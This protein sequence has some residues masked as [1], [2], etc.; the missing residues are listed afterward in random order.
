MKHVILNGNAISPSKIVCIGRNYVEHIQELENEM[1][2]EP[3]IFIKPNSAIS[4]IVESGGIEEIH[5]ESEICFLVKKGGIAAIGVGLDLTKR[6]VQQKL[7]AKGLPW[8]RAKSFDKSAVFS[9]F[10]TCS[11]DLDSYQMELYV[12]NELRQ[13]ATYELM[14]YKPQD[15]ISY[16]SN[17][18][19]LVDGDIVMTGTPKGVGLLNLGDLLLARIYS[20][21][22]LLIEKSWCVT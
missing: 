7:K 15:L 19:T 5:Y 17:D 12:N 11:S 6:V 13:H 10:I 22:E 16:I 1:P 14:I 20:G 9:E 21:D 4:D 2:T 18:F 3:V 8:E